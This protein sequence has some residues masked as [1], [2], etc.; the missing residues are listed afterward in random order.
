[1]I[2]LVLALVVVAIVVSLFGGWIFG[3]AIGAAAIIL[4]VLFLAGF[5]PRAASPRR[6]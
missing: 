2:G 3:I 6:P 4:F 1:M 5:G